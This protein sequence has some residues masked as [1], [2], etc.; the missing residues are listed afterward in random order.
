MRQL[1]E[2]ICFPKSR[3][4]HVNV[5]IGSEFG[6]HLDFLNRNSLVLAIS[7]SGETMD[8]LES[9]K[10]AKQKGA[11]HPASNVLGS[12]LLSRGRP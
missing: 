8:I 4:A 5:A 11:H 2:N 10:K 7:Q 3:N 1:P 12:T 6:Y 9:I